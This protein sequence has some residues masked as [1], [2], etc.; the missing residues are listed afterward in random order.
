MAPGTELSCPR[1]GPRR[2]SA[3]AGRLDAQSSGAVRARLAE[4]SG[5]TDLRR[6]NHGLETAT[7]FSSPVY[8]VEPGCEQ[9]FADFIIHGR[10]LCVGREFLPRSVIWVALADTVSGG[11]FRVPVHPV[12]AQ[13]GRKFCESS[14]DESGD[15]AEESCVLVDRAWDNGVVEATLMGKEKDKESRGGVRLFA[16]GFGPDGV[17]YAEVYVFRHGEW[18]RLDA[19]LRRALLKRTPALRGG[20]PPASPRGSGTSASLS[21]RGSGTSA[22]LSP[23]SA[24]TIAPR[25]SGTSAS[26]QSSDTDGETLPMARRAPAVYRSVPS[27]PQ[28]S[29]KRYPGGCSITRIASS[30]PAVDHAR[31]PQKVSTL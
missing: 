9:V 28:K 20:S 3:P 18:S 13:R 24:C 10:F 12:C 14:T 19:A 26:S 16:G 1:R 17:L 29:P 11:I 8:R 4:V 25:G 22:S 7:M 23:R 31:C 15:S 27:S 21:P 30:G 2:S 5:Y 6:R